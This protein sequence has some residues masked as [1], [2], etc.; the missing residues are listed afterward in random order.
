ML[1]KNNKTNIIDFLLQEFNVANNGKKAIQTVRTKK[2]PNKK[3]NLKNI[4]SLLSEILVCLPKEKQLALKNKNEIAANFLNTKKIAFASVV[5]VSFVLSIGLAYYQPVR[6][7]NYVNFIDNNFFA[8]LQKQEKK[9]SNEKT[10]I[11]ALNKHS[12]LSTAAA[13]AVY[14]VK[15]ESDFKNGDMVKISENDLFGKVV[16]KIAVN[17]NFSKDNKILSYFKKIINIAKLKQKNLSL[18]MQEKLLNLIDE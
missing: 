14:I 3:N 15:H 5:V 2:I 8:F 7:E 16:N 6:V 17:E 10:D 11:F 1:G 4:S 9:I 18:K 12:A 13:K